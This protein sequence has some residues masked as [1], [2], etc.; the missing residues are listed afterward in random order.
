[1]HTDMDTALEACEDAL[2]KWCRA[3]LDADNAESRHKHMT[4]AKIKAY[5]NEGGV[6]K[7]KEIVFSSDEWLE[8]QIEVNDLMVNAAFFKGQLDQAIRVFEA[9]RSEYS[10]TKRVV[11]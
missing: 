5:T 7:A 3:K 2:K 8:S 4:A 9:A 1:M 10:A 11:G 6:T